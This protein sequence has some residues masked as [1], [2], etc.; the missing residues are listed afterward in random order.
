MLKIVP[1]LFES[2]ND[3]TKLLVVGV[4]LN[5]RFCELA[6]LESYRLLIIVSC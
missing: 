5:L 1:L 6:A 4:L 3:C 2:F